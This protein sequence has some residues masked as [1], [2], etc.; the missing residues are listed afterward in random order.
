MLASQRRRFESKIDRS[1]AC[2]LWKAPLLRGGYATFTYGSRRDGSRRVQMV[3]RIAYELFTGQAI[4]EGYEIDH[5]CKNRA[6]VNPAHLEAVTPRVNKLRAVHPHTDDTKA[7][8]AERRR[9]WWARLR[10]TGDEA[11]YW[12]AV[13]AGR[14]R[15]TEAA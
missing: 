14:Q 1:G 5:L 8:M 9:A 6:C 4:P 3:H 7:R 2:W 15:S 10:A 13:R 12:N 11:A